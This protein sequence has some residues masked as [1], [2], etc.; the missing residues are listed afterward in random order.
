MLLDLEADAAVISPDDPLHLLQLPRELRD[1]IYDYLWQD[2]ILGFR[3][4][5]FIV[6]ARYRN[7]N[8][9]QPP[10]EFPR[11]LHTSRQMRSESV[12]RFY[13][14]ALFSIGEIDCLP[15][16]GH[17]YFSTTS[18]AWTSVLSTYVNTRW[19]R[20]SRPVSVFTIKRICSDLLVLENAKHV[21]VSG[22]E[23][24]W[25][26]H[27]EDRGH[28][29]NLFLEECYDPCCER[30]MKAAVEPS[31][32][33]DFSKLVSLLKYGTHGIRT[34]DITITPMPMSWN[35]NVVTDILYDWSFFDSL[36]GCVRS[37]T[38]EGDDELW[39]SAQAGPVL[40]EARRKCV[41]FRS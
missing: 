17:R 28:C 6:V 3:Q 30:V 11:W 37:I 25:S 23:L 16:Y 40:A 21:K 24:T 41:E 12:E 8:I 31:Q 38:V 20:E 19:C 1:Q 36:P 15:A 33:F 39:D 10:H 32:G 7:Q 35:R 26:V 29:R 2:V 18:K 27:S 22:L 13:A 34:L 9:H 5:D 4:E 14:T